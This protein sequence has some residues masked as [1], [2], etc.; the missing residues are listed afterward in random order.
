MKFH[1]TVA[2]LPDGRCTVAN[3]M[4]CNGATHLDGSFP[5]YVI[6]VRNDRDFCL[7]PEVDGF[8]QW[9]GHLSVIGLFVQVAGGRGRQ[10]A[11]CGGRRSATPSW[12]AHLPE[13]AAGLGLHR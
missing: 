10:T 9:F 6:R 13:K 4:V 3:L 11:S 8:G 12:P 5:G 2:L 1:P 7:V